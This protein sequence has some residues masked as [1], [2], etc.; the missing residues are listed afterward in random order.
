MPRYID[1]NSQEHRQQI[2]DNL[3]PNEVIIGEENINLGPDDKPTTNR[4]IVAEMSEIPPAAEVIPMDV[5]ELQ[6]IIEE[7]RRIIEAQA[8]E[9]DAVRTLPG[10]GLVKA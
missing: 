2:I 7:Q 9:L 5:A 3:P 1:Y 10:G 8:S 6:A 4:L